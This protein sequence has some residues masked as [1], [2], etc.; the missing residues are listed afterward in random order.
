[1]KHEES[2]VSVKTGFTISIDLLS[3]V[4]WVV[5]L[6]IVVP[7]LFGYRLQ[8][9]VGPGFSIDATYN[10]VY[11]SVIGV[12]IKKR[13]EADTRKLSVPSDPHQPEY[14]A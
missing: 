2:E 10:K 9:V 5:M 8:V 7:Q 4:L 12:D 3:V 14:A 6:F 13:E 11:E 1:M